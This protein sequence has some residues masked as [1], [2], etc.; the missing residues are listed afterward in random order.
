M[1][2]IKTAYIRSAEE[3]KS[4]Y[5]KVVSRKISGRRGYVT[6]AKEEGHYPKKD[7][8]PKSPPT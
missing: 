4:G 6:W 3:G 1:K 2:V 8:I 7:K 5:L